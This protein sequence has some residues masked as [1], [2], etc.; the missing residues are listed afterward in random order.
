VGAGGITAKPD[1]NLWF[2]EVSHNLIGKLTTT[3]PLCAAAPAGGCRK[4]AVGQKGSLVLTNDATNNLR[5]ELIWKWL[6]GSATAKVPDFGTPLTT[7][8]YHCAST[9]AARRSSG[10]ARARGRHVRP[11]ILLVREPEGLQIRR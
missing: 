8:D 9:T 10:R 11:E 6:A 7:T 1:G 3:G 5:D 2:A 4:P